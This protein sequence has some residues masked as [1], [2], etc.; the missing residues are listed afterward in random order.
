MVW[1]AI[2]VS[3]TAIPKASTFIFP[4]YFFLFH[5]FFSH[6]RPLSLAWS[7]SSSYFSSPLFLEA[8]TDSIHFDLSR[9]EC[10]GSLRECREFC[11]SE[12]VIVKWPTAHLLYNVC[13][14]FPSVCTVYTSC[15]P[16]ENDSCFC[17]TESSTSGVSKTAE[18]RKMRTSNGCRNS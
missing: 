16:E 14:Y 9:F 13:E 18:K 5:N 10:L 15:F 2:I 3:G 4:V 17:C 6:G 8:S 1:I 7:N 11:P 12:T